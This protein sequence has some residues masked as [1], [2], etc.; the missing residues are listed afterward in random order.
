MGVAAYLKSKQLLPFGFAPYSSTF[1][2][3]ITPYLL[4]SEGDMW[5]MIGVNRP[6]VPIIPLVFCKIIPWFTLCPSPASHSVVLVPPPGT[7]TG[8]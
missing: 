7:Q 2:S 1:I 3:F 8:N 5:A 4:I 6:Y